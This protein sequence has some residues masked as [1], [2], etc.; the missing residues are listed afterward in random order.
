MYKSCLLLF[1]FCIQV[2][3]AQ[4]EQEDQ[5]AAPYFK[6]LNT[7]ANIDRLPLLLTTVDV[8]ITGMVAQVQVTQYYKNDGDKTLEVQYVFPGSPEAAV[9]AVT[10]KIEDRVV[11]AKIKT[12]QKARDDYEAA[13][14]E[15]KTTSLLEQGD[16][17]LFTMNLA[18]VLPGD[19]I[20]V[21]MLYSERLIPT[22]GVYQFKYPAIGRPSVLAQGTTQ[23]QQ[24]LPG[25]GMGFD[26]VVAI[27]TPL[28]LETVN[29]RNHRIITEQTNAN[30][31]LVMLD[32]DESLNFTEDF[33]I[34]YALRGADINTGT[35]VYEEDDM[36][37]FLMM[38]EPPSEFKP[39]AVA[40]REYILVMDSSASMRGA[41]LENAKYIATQLLS[42]L[43]EQD[44]F[45]VVL[46]ATG[47]QVLSTE[48]L[49][50]TDNNVWRA[51]EKIDI[52]NAGGGTNLLGALKNIQ[53]IKPIE[54]LSRSLIVMTDG[55]I[56]VSHET[57]EYIR[58]QSRS[59]QCIRHWCQPRLHR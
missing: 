25:T 55:A 51:M 50:P 59:A 20:E 4:D 22:D 12:K 28:K 9:H 58:K 26:M 46:F 48:S 42:E 8:D 41:P 14:Q 34:E 29:S 5:S 18:N 43:R 16:P 37:Y 1:F 47:S 38:V 53:Q 24:Y 19:E 15:G 40:P 27:H 39:D 33:V 49:S 7:E 17:G 36:G 54:G 2:S 3:F 23:K 31:A 57:L 52:S 45:N 44:Y 10:M 13:K 11:E 21:K 32:P 30:Q 6:V 56:D 35:L